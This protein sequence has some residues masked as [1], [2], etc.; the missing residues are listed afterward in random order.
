[1]R[2]TLFII[3]VMLLLLSS[4]TTTNYYVYQT[5]ATVDLQSHKFATMPYIYIPKGKYVI[6]KEG[7]NIFKKA[8]YGNNKGYVYGTSKLSS[9][10]RLSSKEVK[11][12]TFNIKDS[13]YYY[14]GQK[15]DLALSTK[16]RTKANTSYSR[17]TGG[18]VQ[19]KGYYRKDGTYVRPHTRRAATRRR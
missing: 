4:C 2:N 15:I 19:V 5:T 3:G 9:P 16:A 14:K 1:M 7:N 11:N 17:S 10:I 18:S 8:Q 12:L 13:L 6:I